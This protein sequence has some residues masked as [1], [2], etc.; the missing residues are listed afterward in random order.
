MKAN[1][2]MT[3]NI[4]SHTDAKGTDSY[5]NNLSNKRARMARNYLINKGIA[6]SRLT[7]KGFG[8]SNPLVDNINKDGS[9]NEEGRAINRRTEFVITSKRPE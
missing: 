6:K 2:W 8:K 5:N 1:E 4:E 3:I 7:T 9:D